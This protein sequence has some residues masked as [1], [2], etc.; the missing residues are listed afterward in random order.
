ML[1]CYNNIIALCILPGDIN[2][3]AIAG[4]V[5][6]IGVLGV[7]VIGVTMIVCCLYKRCKQRSNTG[8]FSVL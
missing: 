3:A 7:L 5:I 4:P 2:V 1:V 6:A 8:R